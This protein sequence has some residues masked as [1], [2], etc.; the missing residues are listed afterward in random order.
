MLFVDPAAELP[1]APNGPTH[2]RAFAATSPL[3]AITL[4][5]FGTIPVA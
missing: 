2:K 1:L 3:G 4:S 5:L